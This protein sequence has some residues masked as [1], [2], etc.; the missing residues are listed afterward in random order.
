MKTR[1]VTA[2][3]LITHYWPSWQ[4]L[5]GCDSERPRHVHSYIL[6]IDQNNIVQLKTNFDDEALWRPH[7]IVDNRILN[8]ISY[9]WCGNKGRK[10]FKKKIYWKPLISHVLC[11]HHLVVS[12]LLWPLWHYFI[13]FSDCINYSTCSCSNLLCSATWI[14][15]IQQN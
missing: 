5:Y 1:T 15:L 4:G 13:W 3:F 12:S 9:R 11:V 2:I 10:Q 14:I 7:K 6:E 8:S